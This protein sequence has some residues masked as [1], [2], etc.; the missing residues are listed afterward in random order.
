MNRAEFDKLDIMQQV[1]YIN[2]MLLEGDTVT[3]VCKSIGIGRSTVRDRFKRCGYEYDKTSNNYQSIVEVVACPKEVI[4]IDT[5]DYIQESSGQVV[6]ASPINAKEL[7][8][9]Y[10]TMNTKLEEMYNWYK[11]QSSRDVVAT[12]QLRIDDF[13]GAVV[14]RSYK[15]Y[16]NIQQDFA[17]FCKKNNKYKVQDLLCQFIKEGLEKYNN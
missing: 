15:L 14:T 8:E 9:K 1:E 11:L 17:D 4:P 10:N 12:E 13:E 3:N 2:R 7:F 5:E 16:A 6:E